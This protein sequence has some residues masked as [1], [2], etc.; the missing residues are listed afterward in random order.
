M[1]W[2]Y[3]MVLSALAFSVLANSSTPLTA[4]IRF[5]STFDSV[6][7][8]T[9]VIVPGLFVRYANSYQLFLFDAPLKSG[10]AVEKQ[11]YL[12]QSI[13]TIQPI[14]AFEEKNITRHYWYCQPKLALKDLE[15]KTPIRFV[16]TVKALPSSISPPGNTMPV[17][18]CSY[19]RI[20][21]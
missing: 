1:K 4:T 11:V 2:L 13:Q 7:Q 14:L 21:I 12:P 17:L 9:H 3:V 20:A 6:P 8:N 15:N 10:I 18:T 19:E 16:I 5:Q